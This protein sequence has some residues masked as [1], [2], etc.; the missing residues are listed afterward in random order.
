MPPGSARSRRCSVCL[1]AGSVATRAAICPRRCPPATTRARPSAPEGHHEC[2]GAEEDQRALQD[3]HPSKRR[4]HGPVARSAAMSFIGSA[5]SG[6]ATA[7]APLLAEPHARPPLPV[8]HRAPSRRAQ[9]CPQV[10][11]D[12]ELIGAISV[13]FASTALTVPVELRNVTFSLRL[14]CV[15]VLGNTTSV[16]GQRARRREGRTHG[17][18]GWLSASRE[19]A[20]RWPLQLGAVVALGL[21][22]RV[23]YVVLLENPNRKAGDVL[24][25]P[26]RRPVAGRWRGVRGPPGLRL[27][28]GRGPGGRPSPRLHR[29]PGGRGRRWGCAASSNTSSGRACWAR[30][31]WG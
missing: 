29:V 23:A 13:C 4:D 19:A 11:T 8:A 22:I 16:R 27:A 3:P 7:R 26:P 12:S 20:G 10:A 9:R 5:T 21:A 30:P 31:R 28:P 25:Y 15:C 6:S 1:P 2:G 24:Y 14:P 17:R 18:Q